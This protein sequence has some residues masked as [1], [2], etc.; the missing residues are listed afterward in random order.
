MQLWDYEDKHVR[1]TSINRNTFIGFVDHYTSEL[2]APDGI[3]SISLD[4]DDGNDVY[5]NFAEHEIASIE[6]L[7]SEPSGVR[8][9]G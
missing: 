8:N 1:I 4:P 2:D 3:A 6:I 5:I 7:E 9:I